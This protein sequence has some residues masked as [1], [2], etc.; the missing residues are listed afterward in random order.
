MHDQQ[1]I[2]SE[3][4]WRKSKDYVCISNSVKCLYITLQFFQEQ[5]EYT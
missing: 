2:I 3:N 4:S 5:P 1:L